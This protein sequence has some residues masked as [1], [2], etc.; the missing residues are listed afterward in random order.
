MVYNVE[1]KEASDEFS[2][3]YMSGCEKAFN[4]EEEAEEY[5]LTFEEWERGMLCIKE[6][7]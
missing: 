5:L 1:I 4:S 2:Q 7:K 6:R 3:A